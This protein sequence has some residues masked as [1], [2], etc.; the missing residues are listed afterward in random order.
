M[1]QSKV[2]GE[3][4][5]QAR[6]S[7]PAELTATVDAALAK[8]AVPGIVAYLVLVAIL[9]FAAPAAYAHPAVAFAAMTWMIALGVTRLWIAREM[10]RLYAADPERW[11]SQF[12]AATVATGAS[13]GL[14]CAVSTHAMGWGPDS[15][16]VL[17][18]TAGITAGATSSLGPSPRLVRSYLACMLLPTAF[19]TALFGAGTRLDYGLSVILVMYLAFLVVE[20]GHQRLTFV[21]TWK[22]NLLLEERARELDVRTRGLELVLDTVGQG[23]LSVGPDGSMAR[24][25]SAILE[26]WLGPIEPG[27]KVWD[28]IGRVDPG[29][30]G[31]LELGWASLAEKD[32]ERDLVLAQLPRAVSSRGRTY[33]IDYRPRWDGDALSNVVLVISDATSQVERDKSEQGRRETLTIFDHVVRDRAGFMEFLSEGADLCRLIATRTDATPEETRHWIHTL[34]SNAAVFGL[35]RVAQACHELEADLEETRAKITVSQRESLETLWRTT[36]ERVAG[37]LGQ[38]SD[39]NVITPAELDALTKAL[40]D[41]VPRVKVAQMIDAWRLEPTD[42]RLRRIAEQARSMAERMGKGSLSVVLEANNLRLPAEKWKRFWTSFSHVVRNAIDHGIET[43]N[44]RL[45]QGKPALGTLTLRTFV[46]EGELVVSLEDDGRGIDW[47]AVSLRAKAMRLPHA[48]RKDLEAVL[49]AD[50][51][52]TK[53]ALTEH[54]GRGVGMGAV[55]SAVRAMGGRLVVWSQPGRGTRWEARFPHQAMRAREPRPAWAPLVS[56]RTSAH[57]GAAH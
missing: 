51:M 46:D 50:G 9:V 20:A 12:G 54:S 55:L 24:E 33:E 30:G 8:R 21:E 23:L 48:T 43:E 41:S 25:R 52:S 53:E 42:V 27:D 22:R 6:G 16:L 37:L 35:E 7:D 1:A 47:A 3:D 38:G 18:T 17:V 49:F 13:W 36:T 26:R 14:G 2:V 5:K 10:P 15:L 28:Y 44:E 11:S 32:F 57:N 39:R 19:A 56:R 31:W 29:V 4:T 40:S 45:A 34:K